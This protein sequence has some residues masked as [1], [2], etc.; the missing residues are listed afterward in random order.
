[1][2]LVCED[3]EFTQPLLAKIELNRWI[4]QS[5]YMNLS[6]LLHGFVIVICTSRPLP[7]KTKQKFD[8]DL[9]S[10]E[11]NSRICQICYIDFS[12]LIHGFVKVA[13]CIYR[14]LPNKKQ[15]EV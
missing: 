14:P 9:N 15:A 6:E 1:M 12:K 4:C 11:L 5:C 10:I 3:V 7:N 8:Q 2:T 13:L